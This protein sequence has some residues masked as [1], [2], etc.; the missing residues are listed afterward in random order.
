[1]TNLTGSTSGTGIG[2]TAGAPEFTPC[3]CGVHVAQLVSFKCH[4]L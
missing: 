3:Y 1:M 4:A 2:Y